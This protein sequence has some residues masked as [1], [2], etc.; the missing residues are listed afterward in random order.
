M[1]VKKT[2]EE[3]TEIFKEKIIYLE[4]LV[5]EATK[6]NT[7]ASMKT[8][9][10]NNI[11]IILRNLLIDTSRQTSLSTLLSLNNFLYFKYKVFILSGKNN[12]FP[13]SLLAGFSIKQGKLFFYPRLESSSNLYIGINEW[14]NEI[15]IDDKET[16]DNLVTRREIILAIADKEA[17]H[18]DQDYDKK[19]YKIGRINK[20]NVEM[21]I[22]GVKTKADNNLYYE[23]L[24]CIA[25]ELIDAYKVLIQIFEKPL[26][27]MI[28]KT[29]FVCEVFNLSRNISGY[30]INT[31]I[32][33]DDIS[34]RAALN[35]LN[36]GSEKIITKVSFGK[37][38]YHS[39][40]EG[41]YIIKIPYIDFNDFQYNGIII[42]N[43]EPYCFVGLV[44]S[45]KK[46]II[47]NGSTVSAESKLDKSYYLF[48]GESRIIKKDVKTIKENVYNFIGISPLD[49]F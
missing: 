35:M 37:L 45:G 39:Y 28:K 46:I 3:L 30:R 40:G 36:L 29:N 43:K 1:N 17:A 11:S 19:F 27:K 18:T 49:I 4:S 8:E 22:N 6:T 23:S 5:F 44:K 20:L 31:W 14:L 38:E 41:K 48:P 15:V 9:I 34:G 32:S 2:K 16:E 26:I 13:E 10:C 7:I 42:N 25:Y 24:V 33:G 47:L 21:E 12:L